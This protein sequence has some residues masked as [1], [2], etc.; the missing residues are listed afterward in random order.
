M[1]ER[2]YW[3]E[4]GATEFT[5]TVESILP[6]SAASGAED[7]PRLGVVLDRTLFYPEGGG[8]P[9]DTGVL[10]NEKSGGEL[11]VVAVRE[12]Q[13]AILHVVECPV[14]IEAGSAG[15]LVP[16]ARVQGRINWARRFDHMQQHTGQHVLSQAFLQVLQASTVGFH[17]SAEYVSIDL[18]VPEVI[19]EAVS[20]VEELANQVVF[21]DLA[22]TAREYLPDELPPQVR[23]RLP[24]AVERVRVVH[25]GDF[26]ACACGGT[27]VLRTGQI[28]LIKLNEVTRAHNGTRVI[29]RCGGRALQ[30]YGQ[31]ESALLAVARALGCPVEEAAAGVTALLARAERAEKEREEAHRALL[32]VEARL[33]AQEDSAGPLVK[34]QPGKTVEELRYLARAAAALSGRPVVLFVREPRFSAVVAQ[35]KDTAFDARAVGA[36]IAQ[37][38]G[39]RG[40]GSPTLAQVG[41]KEPLVG[42]DSQVEERLRRLLG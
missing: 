25:I 42:E 12:E 17:L 33:L 37:A 3:A 13:G 23:Q 22:V 41:S 31:K 6:V 9:C 26:D 35:G 32:D 19:P 20:R 29:F 7:R 40:G 27:H 36:E 28:G 38:F 14:G 8:Q 2:L 15:G 39:G 18:D 4:P 16:G 1:K 34:A 30:D 21:R 11:P 5:A 10:R 24:K